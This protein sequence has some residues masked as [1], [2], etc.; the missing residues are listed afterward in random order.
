MPIPFTHADRLRAVLDSLP[1]QVAVLDRDGVIV[2]TNEAWKAFARANGGDPERTGAG[3]NYLDVCRPPGA[4]PNLDE[5]ENI[6]QGITGVLSGA[7][8]GFAAEYDCH[9]PD[10]ERWFMF[11]AGRLLL[12]GEPFVVVTHDNITERKRI[13]AVVQQSDREARQR[14]ALLHTMLANAPIGLGFLGADERFE[15]VNDVF[16]AFTGLPASAHVGRTLPEALP[17]YADALA[18]ALRRAVQTGAPAAPLEIEGP[19]ERCGVLHMAPVRQGEGETL[20]LS[21]IVQDVT[22]LRRREQ[23]L[24]DREAHF[25]AVADMA[26]VMIWMTD[27]TGWCTYL[28][29]RWQEYTGQT[30]EEGRGYGWVDAVHPDDAA[31]A[32]ELFVAHNRARSGFRQE[33]RLR[34]RD[35]RYRWM[36]D[37]ASPRLDEAGAFL[38]FIGSV[39]D[40]DD[41]KRAEL[42]REQLVGELEARVAARTRALELRNRDLQHFAYVATHDLQEPLRK[43]QTLVGLLHEEHKTFIPPDALSVLDRIEQGANRMS[44]LLADAVAFTRLDQHE[45]PWIR[46]NVGDLAREAAADL[47]LALRE[48]GALLRIEAEAEV[49]ADAPQLRQLLNHLLLNAIKYRRP[50]A[51]P[52]VRVTAQWVEEAGAPLCRIRVAD[53]GMGFDPQYAA[54]IFEPFERLHKRGE[55]S[56]T[57]MGLTICRRIAERHGGR[58]YAEAIPGEG[59][60]FTFDMPA[61][62]RQAP[63]VQAEGEEASAA[64]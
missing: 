40:I 41:R 29:A 1:T 33:Y 48:S 21:L 62:Q 4:C 36:V 9:A 23:A 13:E 42:E 55:F 38:G 20:G 47:D 10:E 61:P 19:A 14:L 58:I 5:I 39:V 34:D 12:G 2:L 11:R 54:R 17:R 25:Q 26:P 60:V 53:N 15:Q 27:P 57:G 46:V 3:M 31:R 30:P 49:V 44:Q 7:L 64:A 52:Q 8:P 59:S 24:D 16:A 22:H 6:N 28:N 43:M 45:R 50:D 18:A 32:K 63:P 51:P 37:A 56:G 35:G